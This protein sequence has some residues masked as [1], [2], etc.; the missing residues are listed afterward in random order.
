[1]PSPFRGMD[2][3]LESPAHWRDFHHPIRTCRLTWVK[4]FALPTGVADMMG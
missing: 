2:P 1:M 3:Y 4:P